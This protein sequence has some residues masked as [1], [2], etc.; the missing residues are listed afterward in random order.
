MRQI[1]SRSR[2]TSGREGARGYDLVGHDELEGLELRL[3]EERR[4]ARQGLVEDRPERIDVGGR[5]DA[6][7]AALGLLGGHVTR[8]AEDLSGDGPG[9]VGVH[10]LGQAEVADL[11]DT[12]RGQQDVA[13]LQ[14]AVD[15]PRLVGR[16]DGA[17]EGFD[18]HGRL[19]RG[20]GLRGESL[21]EA[22]AFG[23]FQRKVRA[24]LMRTDRVDRD[25]VRMPE[26]GD[27]VGLGPES[28]A[29]IGR[30][31][32]A[33]GDRLEGNDA[34]ECLLAS[35]VDDA[36]T[37]PAELAEDLV[38]REQRWHRAGFRVSADG[39]ARQLEEY[40][41][42]LPPLDPR[43]EFT[44][45]RRVREAGP[46]VRRLLAPAVELLPLRQEVEE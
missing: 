14:I 20:H 31:V 44:P 39:C 32:P 26:A 29:L 46:I 18:H 21:G 40:V 33:L 12:L 30:G 24:I 38:I 37:S 7:P 22:S 13:G 19:E 8:R 34:I 17:C 3:A 25:D 41:Q 42:P 43:L 1:V 5:P 4:P 10:Q 16:M 45:E 6:F 9:R 23:E 15:D 11:G 27:R 2:G 36:H 35:L 28:F